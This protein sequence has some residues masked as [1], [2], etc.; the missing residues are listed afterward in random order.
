M[1]F[2]IIML[3]LASACV[4]QVRAQRHYLPFMNHRMPK[5]DKMIAAYTDSLRWENVKDRPRAGRNEAG[6]LTNGCLPRFNDNAFRLFAPPTFYHSVVRE[7]MA[8]PAA[9]SAPDAWTQAVD[10]ALMHVY[11]SR[12]DLVDNSDNRLDRVGRILP[13]IQN[14]VRNDMEL[15]GKVAPVPIEPEGE[16]V[17][18][19]V[20]Q[21]NFWT[22]KGDYYLQFLQNFVTDNWYKGGESTYSML[23]SFIM[24]ANY[25]NKQKVKWDN[26]LEVKLG[27]LT[28]RSDSLHSLKTSED[29]IRYTGKL[30]LQA[31]KKWYYTMQVLAYTQFCR[32]YKSNDETVYSDI[33]SPF[34]FN[35]SPGMDYTVEA[36]NKKLTGNVHLA[37]LAYN[38][39]YVGRLALSERYGLKA[40]KHSLHDI[41]SQFTV[42]LAWKFSDDIEW[43]S[44]LYGFTPYDRVELEWENTFTFRFNRYISTNIFV[45]PRFDDGASRDG[46]NGYWQFKEFTSIGFAYSF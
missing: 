39:K 10:E 6:D 20:K 35:I 18:I 46:N 28:S 1:K 32:G 12:P 9:D 11:L 43:K 15:I 16:T 3:L 14:P 22:V 25:N 31:S 36:F 40:G 17:K 30:G 37:P 8:L 45:F 13:G 44:R 5:T 26:K 29:I 2:K 38:F 23:G 4:F 21:P 41:G 27:F 33:M 34:N 19:L 7:R 42:E 24:E